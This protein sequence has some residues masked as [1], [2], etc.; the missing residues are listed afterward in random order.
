MTKRKWTK[1]QRLL[2][3]YGRSAVSTLL[4]GGITALM[5]IAFFVPAHMETAAE[6][7]AFTDGPLFPLFLFTFLIIGLF[8]LL[9]ASMQTHTYWERRQ[10]ETAVEK[11]SFV[12]MASDTLRTPLTGIRWTTELMLSGEF[13]SISDAQKES[14]SNMDVAIVRVIDLVNE[15]L[16]VMQLSGSIIDYNPEPTDVAEL[17]KDAVKDMVSVA[18]SKRIRIGFGQI[19]HDVLIMIDAPL[20]R[21]VLSTLIAGA[22]HLSD[23]ETVVVLHAEP[24]DHT[25]AIGITYR[26]EKVQFKNFDVNEKSIQRSALPI[27]LGNL[28]LTISWEILNAAKAEFWIVDKDEEQTLFIGLPY[29][30]A[31]T[32]KAELDSS[33]EELQ[34]KVQ[35]FLEEN[36]KEEVTSQTA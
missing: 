21:H 4:F 20:I 31:K 24:T 2:L 36:A 28:D 1:I 15:L 8:T 10:V 30:A 7:I 16:E 25:I 33:K 13:G 11:S 5:C 12:R 18:G 14:I 19:S 22:I 17:I 26:G 9:F 6:N 3:L 29:I 35:E 34:K 27:N 32:N 23:I